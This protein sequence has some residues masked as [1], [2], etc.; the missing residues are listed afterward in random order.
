MHHD[1]GAS[2]ARVFSLRAPSRDANAVVRIRRMER[3]NFGDTR[4]V[5]EWALEMRIDHGPGYRIYLCAS[6]RAD[7]DPVVWGRRAYAAAGY[8]AG[9]DAG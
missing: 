2:D 4:S 6:R 7:G 1:R 3:A 5:G 9:S 8:Q